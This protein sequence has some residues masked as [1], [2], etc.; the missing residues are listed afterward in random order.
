MCLASHKRLCIILLSNNSLID[1]LS[2]MK[3]EEEC[4]NDNPF[5]YNCSI[6]MGEK[7]LVLITGLKTML[8]NDII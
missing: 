6:I 4:K 7:Y 1:T 3:L 5:E 2:I 8:A